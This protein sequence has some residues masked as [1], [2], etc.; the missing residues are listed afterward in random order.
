MTGTLFCRKSLFCA[1]FLIVA[2]LVSTQAW[3]QC[4]E[5]DAGALDIVGATANATGEVVTHTVRI[6]NAPNEV[7]SMGFEVT[8]DPAV[9]QYVGCD[10][11]PCEVPWLLFDCLNPEP[12]VVRV[13][14]ISATVAG[15]H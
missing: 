14:G 9:L 10:Q 13:A 8:Y 6:Q 15:L 4:V 1:I 3:G 2:A 7:D 11:G 12:G 5:D